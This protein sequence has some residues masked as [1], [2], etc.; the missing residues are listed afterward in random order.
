[1]DEEPD[2]SVLSKQDEVRLIAKAADGHRDACGDLIRHYQGSL[3]AYLLK[4]SGRPEMAED[5]AQEAFV[6]VLNN[7]DRFDP[8]YRFSTWLFTIARRLYLN[9]VQKHKP[10]YNTDAIGGMASH[11]HQPDEAITDYEEQHCD[12]SAI[13]RALSGLSDEQR[14]ILLLFHQQDWSIAVIAQH[15]GMPEGTVKSHLHRAASS[16]AGISRAGRALRLSA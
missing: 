10:A 13:Q 4:M 8:Q 15:M 16:L 9:A 3:Y 1:L 7:L 14:H 11:D 5:I 2:V 12:R 6:R